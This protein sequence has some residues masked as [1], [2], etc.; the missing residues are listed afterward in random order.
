VTTMLE[1]ALIEGQSQAEKQKAVKGEV[2]LPPTSHT[3]MDLIITMAIY[4]PRESFQTLF[5]IATLIVAKNDDPQL[6]KKAYKLIPRLAESETGKSALQ[7][8]N[9]E[10]QKLLIDSKES[11]TAPARR[12]RLGALAEVVRYLPSTDLH[13]IPSILAEV[14]ISVKEVNEKARLA[15]FDLMVQMGEKLQEGGVVVNS[16]VSHMPDDAPDATASLEEYFTMVSAGLGGTNPHMVSATIT[17]LTRI[18]YRFRESLPS[19]LLTEM[20]STLDVFLTSANREIV[21][22][23]LGFVKVAVISLPKEL[24]TPRLQSLIQN[25]MVWSHEHKAHFKQKVKHIIERMIRRFGYDMIE[26][27]TPDEDKKLIINI[28]KTRDRNKRK[29]EAGAE[30]EEGEE[31]AEEDGEAPAKA[32]S[33]KRANKFES[34]FDEQLYGSDSDDIGSDASDDEV[35]GRSKKERRALQRGGQTYIVE[36]ENEPLD[37][38]G[39]KALANISSTK[40]QKGRVAPKQ[41]E[42]AKVNEDGKLILG[43]DDGADVMDFGDDAGDENG[44]GGVGAYVDAIKGK[45]A[46]QRGQNGRIKFSNKRSKD[47]DEMEVDDEPAPIR[48]QGS[49]GGRGG[50][51]RGGFG[52]RGG[53][54]RGGSGGRG[55][56]G[57]RAGGGG[58][59]GGPQTQRRGLGVEKSRGGGGRGGGRVMKSPRGRFGGRR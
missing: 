26:R 46:Y 53:R 34:E 16:K 17:A 9:A 43:D 20:V 32:P 55:G 50:A 6:Q 18:L 27:N 19:D 12:D 10:L 41:R 7:E 35:F 44:E 58:S 56:G 57:F 11:V 52:D 54:G 33:G 28:R 8:R 48:D 21:R 24:M 25:L 1:G 5:N 36:D 37:L 38:L 45:D 29:K 47:A 15:A 39:R 51:G 22:S 4:L 31:G 42:R 49:R 30:G 23:V 40:P 13:F 2:K 3:L 59:R 14:V